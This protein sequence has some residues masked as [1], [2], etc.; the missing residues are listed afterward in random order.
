MG[1]FRLA[2]WP[3]DGLVAMS[4]HNGALALANV[5]VVATQMLVEKVASLGEGFGVVGQ[6][7]GLE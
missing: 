2:D 1:G 6:V 7:E 5:N 3:N 4:R